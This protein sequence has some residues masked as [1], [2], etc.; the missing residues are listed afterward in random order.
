MRELDKYKT[1]G[2]EKDK[3]TPS[4]YA[5]QDAY[6]DP[7]YKLITMQGGTWSGKTYPTIQ[8]LKHHAEVSKIPLIISVVSHSVPHLK[9]GAYR[10]MEEIAVAD[11]Y[12]WDKISNNE[13]IVRFGCSKI[14]FISVDKMKSHGGRRHVL[15]VNESNAIPFDVFWNLWIRTKYKTIHDFNPIQEYWYHTE[16]EAHDNKYRNKFIHSIYKDNQ[17]CPKETTESLDNETPG[18]NRHKIYCLGEL[19]IA[20]G[21]IFE[22][23]KRGEFDLSLPSC[24]GQDFGSNDPDATIKCAYDKKTNNFYIEEKFYADGVGVDDLM[25]AL[26]GIKEK[27]LKELE[28]NRQYIWNAVSY[29][30]AFVCDT[31]DRRMRLEMARNG[32]NVIPARKYPDC[33]RTW[34][35]ALQSVNIIVC[36][37][38]P[39][40]E[41]ELRNFV[42]NDKNSQI[43]ADGN[44]HAMTA[45]MY[46]WEFLAS[47]YTESIVR[48]R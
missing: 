2:W 22:N 32:L 16:V 12:D 20:E 46:A 29:N 14:E 7:K 35:R 1:K 13:R 28:A 5:L 9:I 30:P 18:T 27:G 15:F 40:I 26:K 19:G 48:K 42:W 34:I 21:V 47:G 25:S 6:V 17:F 44:D 23:W 24:F 38:S 4:Y 41:K 45:M 31:N 33:V 10:D 43:P 36:G 11:G 39:H 3:Y 37:E 8:L